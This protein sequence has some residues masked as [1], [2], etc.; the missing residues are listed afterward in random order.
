VDADPRSNEFDRIAILLVQGE[1]QMQA[2]LDAEG[3]RSMAESL[4]RARALSTLP[5][6]PAA[7]LVAS[8]L[9]REAISLRKAHHNNDAKVLEG[10]R[11]QALTG[12]RAGCGG[13]TVSVSSLL[14]K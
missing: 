11:K 1:V 13:C 3:A 9:E 6:A 2:G 7:L 14:A 5:P 12:V 8:I 4:K 10:E